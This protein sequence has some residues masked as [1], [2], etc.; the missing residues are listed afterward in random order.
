MIFWAPEILCNTASQVLTFKTHKFNS[1]HRLRPALLYSF[2]SHRQWPHHP[3]ISICWGL[4]KLHL[5]IASWSLFRDPDTDIWCQASDSL[6]G[7]FSLWVPTTAEAALSLMTSAGLSE[8]QASAVLHD[9]TVSSKPVRCERL[10]HITEFGYQ[11]GLWA[12]LPLNNSFSVL[13]L[14]KHSQ[15]SPHWWWS[16]LNHH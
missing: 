15:T 13:T 10:W 3:D 8:C 4:Q 12:W 14:R 7:S 1:T 9:P 16:L 6:H 5:H 11:H 2:C